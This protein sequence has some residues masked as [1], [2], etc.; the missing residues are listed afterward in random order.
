M[1]DSPLYPQAPPFSVPEG[2][3]NP[4]KPYPDASPFSVPKQGLQ[5]GFIVTNRVGSGTSQSEGEVTV[6]PV[7]VPE[8]FACLE[9]PP[10]KCGPPCLRRMTIGIRVRVRVRKLC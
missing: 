8:S 5:S 2:P 6:G 1:Q 7:F 3:S 10:R 4:V 9:L